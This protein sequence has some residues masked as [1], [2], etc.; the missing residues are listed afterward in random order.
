MPQDDL[1]LE[2]VPTNPENAQS[3]QVEAPAESA[4][5]ADDPADLV[6]GMQAEL[7]SEPT[8]GNDGV[9]AESPMIQIGMAV[10][11][12]S[13]LTSGRADDS[14][15][16]SAEPILLKGLQAEGFLDMPE[17]LMALVVGG[18]LA[19]NMLAFGNAPWLV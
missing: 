12:A 10:E 13:E 4:V 3:M 7:G 19:P 15:T 2:S 17:A 6:V 18:N 5:Q 8:P 11:R 14:G 16:G 1:T 9:K